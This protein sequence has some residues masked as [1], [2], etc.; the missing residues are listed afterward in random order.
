MSYVSEG[1]REFSRIW[2]SGGFQSRIR[3]VP[4]ETRS[5][6]EGY[7]SSVILTAAA[8]TLADERTKGLSCGLLPLKSS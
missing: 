6:V 2:D 4:A 3:N 5:K 7:M 1:L 8:A